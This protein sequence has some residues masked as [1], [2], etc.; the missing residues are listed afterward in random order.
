MSGKTGTVD[1]SKLLK[2]L[3]I[4]TRER[5]YR[6]LVDGTDKEP[7]IAEKYVNAAVE[8]RFAED[9]VERRRAFIS[10][11]NGEI[12]EK[13]REAALEEFANLVWNCELV[14]HN[15]DSMGAELER[16]QNALGELQE[17]GTKA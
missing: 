16:L 15:A 14:R 7:G 11:M 10:S 17:A 8:L 2:G 3:P 6:Q 12:T 5:L 4:A 1:Y 13:V 9:R